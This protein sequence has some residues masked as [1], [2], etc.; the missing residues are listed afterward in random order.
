MIVPPWTFDT[1]LETFLMS[2]A[3]RLQLASGGPT[4]VRDAAKRLRMHRL[5]PITKNSLAQNINSA[6]VEKSWIIHLWKLIKNEKIE[7]DVSLQ[8][9]IINGNL[10][11][12]LLRYI[13]LS[14]NFVLSFL[15]LFFL[16]PIVFIHFFFNFLIVT[17]YVS[18]TLFFSVRSSKYVWINK[19]SY[20]SV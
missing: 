4:E 5:A 9:C 16:C 3:L 18:P 8:L 2:R 19:R 7:F 12:V 1:C 20:K 13:N 11:L 6:T 10:G 15:L 17:I 14:S